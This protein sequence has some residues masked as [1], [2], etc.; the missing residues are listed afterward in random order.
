MHDYGAI[1]DVSQTLARVISDGLGLLQP[2]AM[3][4]IHRLDETPASDPARITLFLY[5]VMEDPNARNQPPTVENGQTRRAPLALTLRYLLTPWGGDADTEQR[6]LGRTLQI[7]HDHAILAGPDLQ[8]GLAGSETALRLTPNPLSLEDRTRIWQAV[9]K[10]YRLSTTLEVKVVR[11]RSDQTVDAT[12]V[13]TRVQTTGES[14]R[15]G[16][17]PR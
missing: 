17:V 2:P 6:I 8:G 7:L 16:G 15:A 12:P 3:A 5:E 1:S 4:E 13:R 11:I 10:S 9:Q 14:P